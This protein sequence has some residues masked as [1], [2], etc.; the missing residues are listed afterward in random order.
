[1]AMSVKGWYQI[2]SEIEGSWYPFPLRYDSNII[3]GIVVQPVIYQI[4][5]G[6]ELVMVS[7]QV[8]SAW[9][10]KTSTVRLFDNDGDVLSANESDPAIAGVYEKTVYK[11]YSTDQEIQLEM[12]GD[13]VQGLGT[14]FFEII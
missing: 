9:D 6:D 12:T 4:K 13:S 7:L 10:D 2:D 5:A 3:G 1:M 11:K 14:I 8:N